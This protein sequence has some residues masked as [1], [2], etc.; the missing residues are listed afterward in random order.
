MDSNGCKYTKVFYDNFFVVKFSL[1]NVQ[2]RAGNWGCVCRCWGMLPADSRRRSEGVDQPSYSAITQAFRILYRFIWCFH[3]K[4]LE[5]IKPRIPFLFHF[6][7]FFPQFH[8]FACSEQNNSALCLVNYE[9]ICIFAVSYGTFRLKTGCVHESKRASPLSSF[10]SKSPIS[11]NED[12]RHGTPPVYVSYA[13]GLRRCS[14]IY[15][16]GIF[17][18]FHS[19]NGVWRYQ[20]QDE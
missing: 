12:E 4:D 16:V 8:Y 9:L 17:V 13:Y 10:E 11:L 15:G 18:S 5:A 19:F 7:F 2:K 3:R 1:I 14:S 20:I 6:S